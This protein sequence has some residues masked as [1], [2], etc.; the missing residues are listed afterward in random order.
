MTPDPPSAAKD[1]SLR[2]AEKADIPS[3]KAIVDAAYTKYIPRIGKPPAPMTEDYSALLT[4]H[5]VFTLE[6]NNPQAIVGAVVL[7]HEPGTDE[8]QIGN[9]VVDVAAQGRGYGG[10]LMRYAQDFARSRGCKAL[11]LYTNVK[12]YENLELYPKMGFVESERRVEDGYERV[13]FCKE[14]SSS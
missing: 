14:L 13:Y 3:I 9:L 10:V 4:T 5:D 6:T 12:M 2:R 1:I 7:K 11:T 8:L